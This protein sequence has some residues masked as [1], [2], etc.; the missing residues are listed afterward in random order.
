MVKT[1]LNTENNK[2]GT[3]LRKCRMTK[4]L[5]DP[6]A[7]Q[8]IKE[9]FGVVFEAFRHLSTSIIHFKFREEEKYFNVYKLSLL[10]SF[11]T[12]WISIIQLLL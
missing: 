3:C 5:L 1:R 10:N 12:N 6:P 4:L 9:P 2:R 8:T 11:V 7:P